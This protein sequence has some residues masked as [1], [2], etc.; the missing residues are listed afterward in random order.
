MLEY[1]IPPGTPH[2]GGALLALFNEAVAWMVARGQ[3]GQWGDRPFSERAETRA[4]VRE[5]A[6]HPGLWIAERDGEPLG[7]LIV[8][9][10]PHHVEPIDRSELYIEL[11]ISPRAGTRATG[12]A[13][14]SS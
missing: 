9:A 12:S 1:E 10:R 8:G 13:R 11:L 5:F 4:R 6:E 7:A 2:V 3:T 14:G